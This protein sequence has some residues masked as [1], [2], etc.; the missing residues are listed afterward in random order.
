MRDKKGQE[1]QS[2]QCRKSL[3]F[4]IRTPDKQ[5]KKKQSQFILYDFITTDYG[6][7]TVY[8]N[9]VLIC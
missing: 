6:I 7:I 9:S 5:P 8:D 4:F 1:N 2:N 3:H